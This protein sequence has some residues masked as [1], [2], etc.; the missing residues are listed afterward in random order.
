MI[1]IATKTVIT[2]DEN[3]KLEDAVSMMHQHNVRDIVV[4]KEGSLRFGMI[5]ANDL[6]RFRVERV[7]FETQVKDLKIDHVSAVRD[8]TSL[9]EALKEVHNSC[10]CLCV[11]DEKNS[12]C[13]FVT[14]TDIIGS[15]DPAVLMKEQKI[16]DILWGNVIKHASVETQTCDVLRMMSSVILDSVIVYEGKKAVGIITTKDTINLLNNDCDLSQPVSRYM[17]SPIRTIDEDTSIQKAL[18]F[19]QKEQFKRVIVS[20]KKGEIIGQIS[21]QELLA[22]V[23]SR[24]AENLKERDKQLEEVNKLLEAR[25]SKYEEMAQI[26]PLTGLPNRGAFEE[27]MIDEFGRIERY[28]SQA[29]SLI[30]FDID[31]FKHIN[32]TYGHLVGDNVLKSL[33]LQC[34]TL[35]RTN[36]LMARWGGEEFAI[37]LPLI[38][39]KSAEIVAEKLRKH[40]EEYIFEQV[41]HISCSFGV[42]EYQ[43]GDTPNSLLHRTDS[44]MYQAKISGRNRVIRA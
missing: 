42:C 32:D 30:F 18:E 19:I 37:I 23:Y 6:I 40:I 28:S 14:Y 21:Q 8:N 34:K 43:A 1:D 44:A 4:T 11:I 7:P 36:D 2:I 17:S 10:N 3:Q 33:S 22:K 15:I 41:G 12:L 5:T 25:A 31:H 39:D 27:K 20:N 9:S 24:W 13:G 26:D 29:F 16:K 38:D 35:L